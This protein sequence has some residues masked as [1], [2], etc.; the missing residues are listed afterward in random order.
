[1]DLQ[2]KSKYLK[3]KNKYLELKNQFG[4]NY[5]FFQAV[6]DCN[7]EKIKEFFEL[8]VKVDVNLLCS[9]NDNYTAL[10]IA[11]SIGDQALEVVQYLIS[12]GANVN[13]N[14]NYE[15]N[16]ALMQASKSDNPSSLIIQCLGENG[17]NFDLEDR[18]CQT[19][20][21]Q[22]C[23]IGDNAKPV[24]EA[25]IKAGANINYE[26]MWGN[27]ALSCA[28][29]NVDPSL[30][31]IQCLIDNGANINLQNKYHGDT[32]LMQFFNYP[33]L[34]QK[35]QLSNLIYLIENRANV[36]LQNTQGYT[37]LM[38]ASLYGININEYIKVLIQAGAI[39]DLQNN[40]GHSALYIA[41]EN[42]NK[43][44]LFLLVKEYI[45]QLYDGVDPTP[46]SNPDPIVTDIIALSEVLR[47]M[48]FCKIKDV[49]IDVHSTIELVQTLLIDL[50]F[51]D[52]DN[53][54]NLSESIINELC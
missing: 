25:C 52:T 23:I 43:D 54:S 17:A 18:Y 12:K 50:G 9:N 6:R 11:S 33:Y 47:F 35:P 28:S 20:L 8:E 39:L 4:G 38:Y 7:L 51:K 16:T 19:A 41:K 37:A 48:T 15:R 5:R 10:I 45:K 42:N 30:S 53:L 46:S 24:V 44:I 27:T 26:S 3:Y 32:T 34:S 22:A 21:M 29:I 14:T 13:N 40:D 31:I 1:M 36:N 49:H 2:Y